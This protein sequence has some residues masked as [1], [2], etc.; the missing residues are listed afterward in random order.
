M[1]VPK[2]LIDDALEFIELHYAEATGREAISAFIGYMNG[3]MNG[4]L[5]AKGMDT[6][7]TIRSHVESNENNTLSRY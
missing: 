7:D 1:E 6:I 2:Q 4:Y 5:N 3:Y